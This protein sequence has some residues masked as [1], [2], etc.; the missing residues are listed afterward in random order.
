MSEVLV[1]TGD[2]LLKNALPLDPEPSSSF[3]FLQILRY[4][5][6]LLV[7]I[8]LIELSFLR[9]KKHSLKERVYRKFLFAHQELLKQFTEEDRI[10]MEHTLSNTIKNANV[11]FRG[12]RSKPKTKKHVNFTTEK[13]SY[14]DPRQWKADA[15]DEEAYLDIDDKPAAFQQLNEGDVRGKMIEEEFAERENLGKIN[16]KEEEIEIEESKLT[17]D[18]QIPSEN[19]LE[20]I[21]S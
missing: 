3:D 13:N 1:Q 10:N 2:A 12:A 17:Q 4:L 18:T 8:K 9:R 11:D 5:F 19:T 6:Y 16:E 7:A 15:E 21:V 20:S 14:Y